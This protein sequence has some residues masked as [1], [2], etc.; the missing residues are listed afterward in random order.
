MEAD[1]DPHLLAFYARHPISA[2][3]IID[4]V[5]AARGNLDG[6]APQDLWPHDQD[7]YGGLAANEHLA[8]RAGLKPGLKVADFCAGLGGPARWYAV[9][10]D[11]DVTGIDISPDRVR[12]AADLTRLVGLSERVRVLE[13]SVTDVPLED[14]SMDAVLSQEALLH[15]PDKREVLREAYRVLKSGGRLAFSD[16]VAPQPLPPEV[17][18]DMWTGIAA[19]TLQSGDGYVAWLQ[20]L[21]FT[22]VLVEDLTPEWVVVLAERQK[23][24]VALMDE[25]KRAGAPA[26]DTAFA[27][28]YVRFVGHVKAGRLG[29]VRVSAGKA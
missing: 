14:G 13:A 19:R 24:Y 17:A 2:T 18:Q 27:E 5:K 3:H 20:E 15:V 8:A 22:D 25:A 9:T 4:K 29:G 12:G 26:G 7:H 16:W 28:S 11:V 6:V 23:M 21:G 1:H 10:H